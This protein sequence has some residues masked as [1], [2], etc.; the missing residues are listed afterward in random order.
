MKKPKN[1]QS[2]TPFFDEES[3]RNVLQDTQSMLRSGILTIGPNVAEFEK[4]FAQY[5]QAKHAVAVNSGTAALEIAL[6]HYG[7]KG[8]EVI[9]PTNTFI[10]TPN[11]VIFAGGKPVFADIRADTL[12]TDPEDV[13]RK[14]TSQT[15][16]VIV[17]HIAGLPCPQMS[18]LRELCRAKGLFLVEDAAHAHG[19]MIDDKKVGKLADTACFSF[20]PTKVITSG[21]GGMIVTDNPKF[22]E[23]ARFMRNH[24]QDNR[25]L[26]VLFGHNWCMSESCAIIGKHQLKKLDWF[27]QRRN[28]I[29][30]QYKHLLNCV[31][32][33]TLFQIPANI[34]H[35]YY[36]YPL[37]LDPNLDRAKV[38][39]AMKD[40]FGV[41]TGSVYYPPCH[42]HPYYVE[43]FGCKEGD[44]P[45]S[46]SV[47]KSV[48]C[49]PMHPSLKAEDTRYVA[50]ALQDCLALA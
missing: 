21:E 11:S 16:G 35:S 42:L 26:M 36:K 10:A 3:I 17:V 48:L 33:V 25:R 29:A 40:K 50:Q 31:D 1:I 37:L 15:V 24:G 41:E 30:N 5:C 27:L 46:E 4:Q 7:V 14:I 38:A 28:E 44:L 23:E 32:K 6:R 13:K 19:A 9:V 34:K 12:C 39:A 20:Y 49:L 8:K 22:A 2:V 43:N 18:E 45:V 47:L